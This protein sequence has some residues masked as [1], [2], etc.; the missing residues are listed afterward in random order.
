MQEG[1]QGSNVDKGVCCTCANE[2]VI[3]SKPDGTTAFFPLPPTEVEKVKAK[4]GLTC[5]QDIC[6]YIYT[7][8][9][10]AAALPNSPPLSPGAAC[11][12]CAG[13]KGKLPIPPG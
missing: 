11:R 10:A 4:L 9:A 5:N 2:L 12:L 13:D 6:M 3:I 8:T 7:T 1:Q